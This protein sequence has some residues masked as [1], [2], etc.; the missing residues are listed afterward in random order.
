MLET[1]ACQPYPKV[2]P[3]PENGVLLHLHTSNN[4]VNLGHL[5]HCLHSLSTICYKALLLRILWYD[6]RR[7]FEEQ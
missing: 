2:Q 3:Q 6:L 4:V 5:A 1:N 7:R